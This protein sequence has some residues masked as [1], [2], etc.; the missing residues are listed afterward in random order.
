MGDVESQAL[1]S[2]QLKVHKACV[3]PRSAGEDTVKLV[4]YSVLLK[5]KIRTLQCLQAF[6]SQTF[7]VLEEIHFCLHKEKKKKNQPGWFR[8]PMFF[9][10]T[11]WQGMVEQSSFCSCTFKKTNVGFCTFNTPSL[12]EHPDNGEWKVNRQAR[13][14]K[15]PTHRDFSNVGWWARNIVSLLLL[16][17]VNRKG[18]EA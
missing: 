15:D 14:N 16:L 5:R 8:L 11:Q 12:R 10:H 18:S 1:S 4:F 3:M 9:I 2:S 7:V 17:Q 13:Q 6:T